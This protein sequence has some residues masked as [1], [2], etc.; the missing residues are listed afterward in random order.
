VI[1]DTNGE[2]Q[3][4]NVSAIGWLKRPCVSRSRFTS[5][6]PCLRFTRHLAIDRNMNVLAVNSAGQKVLQTN[7][8]PIHF[9]SKKDKR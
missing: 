1:A 9:S 4:D 3:F 7:G 8:F 5:D 6:F 2:Y